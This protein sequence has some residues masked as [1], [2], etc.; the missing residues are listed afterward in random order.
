MK[1]MHGVN[2]DR[3]QGVCQFSLQIY[4]GNGFICMKCGAA[5]TVQVRIM[6]FRAM[7]PFSLVDECHCFRGTN[8]L[9]LQG[10]HVFFEM[11]VATC[12]V[13]YGVS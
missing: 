8:C 9:R 10:I 6:V 11:L 12:L 13:A 4:R 3:Q 1:V 7:T 5:A 2:M